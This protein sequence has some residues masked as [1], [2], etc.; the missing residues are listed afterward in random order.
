MGNFLNIPTGELR[1]HAKAGMS[2]KCIRADRYWTYVANI[3]TVGKTY[4]LVSC[5]TDTMNRL[6]IVDDRGEFRNRFLWDSPS[7]GTF[8]LIGSSD[9]EEIE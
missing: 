4:K 8:V 1:Q 5:E 7:V 2:I 3:L 6:W 9:D